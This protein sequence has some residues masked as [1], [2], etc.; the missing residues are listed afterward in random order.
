MGH[1]FHKSL[2]LTLYFTFYSWTRGTIQI[3]V[4][5]EFLGFQKSNRMLIFYSL[6]NLGYYIRALMLDYLNLKYTSHF[7]D[8]YMHLCN[9]TF[10]L[11]KC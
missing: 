9:L 2:L 5:T 11:K 7:K 6:Y 8:L 10:Q 1:Y 3:F 4:Y